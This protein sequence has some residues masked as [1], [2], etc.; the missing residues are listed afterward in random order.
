MPNV[1]RSRL[2]ALSDKEFRREVAAPEPRPAR[3]NFRPIRLNI[4]KYGTSFDRKR[5]GAAR[6]MTILLRESDRVLAGASAC[7]KLVDLNSDTCVAPLR[8]LL[9][10]ANRP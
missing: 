10:A 7:W 6:M 9:K 5:G 2:L 3:S 1:N 8:S 4:N